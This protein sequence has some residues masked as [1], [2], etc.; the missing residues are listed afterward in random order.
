M[1]IALIIFLDQAVKYWVLHNL[2]EHNGFVFIPGF[3]GILHQ[4]NTGMAFSVLADN[5]VFMRVLTT[6]LVI[7]L[8]FLAYRLRG[9]RPMIS[10]AFAF[11]L[12]GAYSNLIDRYIYGYVIDYINFLFVDFA[13]FNI[14]DVALNIGAFLLLLD[15]ILSSTKKPE[16][17]NVN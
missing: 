7:F 6:G 8:S 13:V 3:I 12:G 11:I 1:I 17:S 9:S 15:M 14:A 10:I 2:A 4:H 5:P 16:V